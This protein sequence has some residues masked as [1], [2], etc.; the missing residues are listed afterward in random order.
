M[1]GK[2]V[3]NNGLSNLATSLVCKRNLVDMFYYI[4]QVAARAVKLVLEGTF[5]TPILGK[6]EVVGGK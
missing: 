1:V 6:G 4:R 5:G 3:V 2:K